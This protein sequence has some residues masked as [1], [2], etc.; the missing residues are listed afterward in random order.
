MAYEIPGFRMTLPAAS[1]LATDI[2]ILVA[3]G[4]PHAFRFVSVDSSGQIDYSAA[5]GKDTASAL[6]TVGVLQ[7]DPRVEAEPGS[8]MVTGVSK[9][10][11]GT[12]GV[13][14]GQRVVTVDSTTSAGRITDVTDSGDDQIAVGIALET[15]AV[16]EVGA[17]LLMTP[18]G[19]RDSVD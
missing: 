2:A 7:D 15:F 10:E 5:T 13:T 9:V 19:D 17:V 14:A 3:A 6:A 12:G 4:T 11:A 8:I 18:G 16:G 1:A